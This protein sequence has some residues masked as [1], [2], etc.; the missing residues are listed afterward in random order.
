MLSCGVT[1]EQLQQPIGTVLGGVVSR[2]GY[3]LV[4]RLLDDGANILARQRYIGH[5]GRLSKSSNSITGVTAFHLASLFWNANGLKALIDHCGESGVSN[6]KELLRSCDDGGRW[7]IHWATA[8][9]GSSECEL[10]ENNISDRLEAT[11]KLLLLYSPESVNVQDKEGYTPLYHLLASHAS[12]VR[13]KHFD[14]ALKHLLVNGAKTGILTVQNYNALHIVSLYRPQHKLI[15]NS[16]LDILAKHGADINQPDKD[17]N[18]PLHLMASDLRQSGAVK[19][20]LSQGASISSTNTKG[21]T[22]HHQ[23]MQNS[24]LPGQTTGH[25]GYIT[26]TFEEKIKAQ[27]EMLSVL[28]EAARRDDMMDQPNAA[29]RTPRQLRSETRIKWRSMGARRPLRR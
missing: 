15:D 13:R 28:Q 5:I 4:K 6:A 10:L 14:I 27:D 18:T 8:G 29:G 9:P 19:F 20:L 16:L 3:S 11:L 26:P 2:G 21:D 7:P 24:F 25:R 22:A 23:L 1:D 12:C 17:G